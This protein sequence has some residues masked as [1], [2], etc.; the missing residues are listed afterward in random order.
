MSEAPEVPVASTQSQ[1]SSSVTSAIRRHPLRS[2][3]VCLGLVVIGFLAWSA[4]WY[5][6]QVGGSGAGAGTVVA[7]S[8][9]SSV[10]AVAA[11]LARQHV[12]SSTLAFRFY[13][14]FHGTP[15]VQPGDYLM[16]HHEGYSAILSTLAA[17]PDVFPVTIPAGFTVFETASR[18]GE[19]PRHDASAFLALATSGAVHSPWQPPGSTNLDGLLGTGTYLLLPGESNKTL[20]EKMVERFDV[21]ADRAGLAQGA[22]ALGVTPYQAVTIA[23]IVEKEGVYAQNLAKVSRVIYNR[24]AAGMKLQMDATVLY[25]ENRDGGPVSS[26]DLALNTPYNTYLYPG[27]TPTPICFPSLGSL[28]AALDPAPGNWLYF[29]L[30]SKDGTEAFSDTLAGQEANERLA[31]SRGVP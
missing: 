10:S 25:S 26:A 17:G 14:F 15:V 2:L 16:H 6:D 9:G 7:V 23:S 22:A 21:E 27:L 30:V 24:L 8:E 29:V 11:R 12:V 13:L 5:E 20:L 3:L 18:V 31:K 19:I 1:R 4:A 28:H